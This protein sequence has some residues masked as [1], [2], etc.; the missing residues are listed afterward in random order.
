MIRP[1]KDLRLIGVGDAA[2]IK[3]S[4]VGTVEDAIRTGPLSSEGDRVVWNEAFE[5]WMPVVPVEDL[6]YEVNMARTYTTTIR[7]GVERAQLGKETASTARGQAA[8]WDIVPVREE[9]MELLLNQQRGSIDGNVYTEFL[10]NDVR[11]ALRMGRPVYQKRIFT[12]TQAYTQ[13]L[14]PCPAFRPIGSVVGSKGERS[15]LGLA[16]QEGEVDGARYHDAVLVVDNED[17]RRWRG[18]EDNHNLFS[19]GLLRA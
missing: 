5:G 16:I 8:G 10:V 11:R 6:S 13:G 1:P 14:H 7:I 2:H 4:T 19:K 3:S 17:F 18:H 9:N 15:D 12:G